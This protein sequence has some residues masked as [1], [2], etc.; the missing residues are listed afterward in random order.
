M[1]DERTKAADELNAGCIETLKRR[2]V[3]DGR[4]VIVVGAGVSIPLIPSGRGLREIMAEKC[5]IADD[6]EEYYWEFFQRA[7]DFNPN[8]YRRTIIETFCD[9]PE[10]HPEACRQIVQLPSQSIITLNYDDH[11][12]DAFSQKFGMGWEER[13]AVYPVQDKKRWVGGYELEHTFHLLAAHG[14][15]VRDTNA[16]IPD[17]NATWPDD[18]II[19][20][21]EQFKEHYFDRN[22]N[23]A[24]FHWWSDLFCRFSCIFIGSS[25]QEPGI[26]AVITA[27]DTS[28][29]PSF[30]A[31]KRI[32]L[33]HVK[34][35]DAQTAH[36]TQIVYPPPRSPLTSVE[37][38]LFDPKQGFR[39]LLEILSGL[40]GQ[41]LKSSGSLESGK[42]APEPPSYFKLS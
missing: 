5:G 24:L 3:T 33:Q 20:T 12:Q 4:F 34:P 28:R 39:G 16:A 41:P 26:E 14:Y 35:L 17:Y 31:N 8:A 27:L 30:L 6:N 36:G 18:G 10:W 32:Q 1:P 2:G 29:N 25:L 11:L 7:K 19:L 40:T 42:R 23:H 37:Q 38:V 21:T 13:F 9:I 22:R 15:R